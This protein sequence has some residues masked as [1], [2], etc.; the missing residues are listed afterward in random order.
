MNLV[1][2]HMNLAV[3]TELERE[4]FL[5][6][7]GKKYAES[8]L[9]AGFYDSYEM[10]LE[11]AS[12]Q[13][14]SILGSEGEEHFFRYMTVGNLPQSE[15]VGTLWWARRLRDN[16]VWIYDIEVDEAFR[17]RG[18]ARQAIA[19]LESWCLEEDSPSISLNVFAFN[20]GAE[21]L[22]REIG[23]CDVSKAMRK[24]LRKA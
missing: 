14:H 21:K 24:D 23:F 17:R 3:M 12:A 16:S 18:Y 13:L 20:V 8:L 10:A 4:E 5:G 19:S 11:K 9:K 6:L 7:Q 1:G 22:Y 2:G 15:R